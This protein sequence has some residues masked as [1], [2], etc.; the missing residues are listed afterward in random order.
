MPHSTSK[1]SRRTSPPTLRRLFTQIKQ[2]ATGIQATVIILGLN[3]A[4]FFSPAWDLF[5]S[6]INQ[7]LN[8]HAMTLSLDTALQ[9]AERVADELIANP[10]MLEGIQQLMTQ[11]LLIHLFY[12]LMVWG[13]LFIITQSFKRLLKHF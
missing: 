13:F 1:N 2:S 10:T 8:W 12:M 5:S 9:E 3:M 4:S 11:V 7:Y 6:Q